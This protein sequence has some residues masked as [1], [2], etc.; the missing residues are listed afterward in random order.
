MEQVMLSWGDIIEKVDGIK[1]EAKTK[2]LKDC[3]L[4]IRVFPLFTKKKEN[5][6]WLYENI[7]MLSKITIGINKNGIYTYV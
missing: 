1:R 4:S 7:Y 6:P 2:S 3:G 5:N